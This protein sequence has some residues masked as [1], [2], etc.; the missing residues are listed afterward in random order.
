MSRLQPGMPKAATSLPW[1]LSDCFSL[2]QHLVSYLPP[3][4]DFTQQ[5]SSKLHQDDLLDIYSGYAHVIATM[6]PSEAIPA[7]QTFV[8][9]FIGKAQELASK[10]SGSATKQELEAVADA[11]EQL[12]TFIHINSHLS[13]SLPAECGNTASEVWAIL[14]ALISRYGGSSISERICSTLRRGLTF[15]GR[16]CIPLAASILDTVTVAFEQTGVSGYVWVGGRV[17]DLLRVQGLLAQQEQELKA[18]LQQ[19]FERMTVKLVAMLSSS[20]ANDVQDCMSLWR[21]V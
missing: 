11:L 17:S 15:F 18:H 2:P 14:S 13:D 10:T 20:T 6:P 12:N 8:A 1:H 4:F 7:L 21:R 5:Y 16:L 9:P 19:A 3:L